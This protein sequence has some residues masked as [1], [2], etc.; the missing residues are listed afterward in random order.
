MRR[1]AVKPHRPR[2]C[3]RPP[4]EP[5]VAPARR[6]RRGRPRSG[7]GGYGLRNRSRHRLQH[8]NR[9]APSRAAACPTSSPACRRRR[10]RITSITMTQAQ[11]L[12]Q[13]LIDKILRRQ[14]ERSGRREFE[15]DVDAQFSQQRRGRRCRSDE[16]RRVGLEQAAWMRLEGDHRDRRRRFRRSR[17]TLDYRA[18]AAMDAV[19]LPNAPRRRVRRHRFGQ[20][21]D[22][23]V[24]Q[25]APRRVRMCARRRGLY[26]GGETGNR[27]PGGASWA[28][29]R[30]CRDPQHITTRHHRAGAAVCYLFSKAVKSMAAGISPG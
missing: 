17:G 29:A 16:R 2:G 25:R 11:T 14:Q 9:V 21:L 30:Y 8:V 18:V 15:E 4:P 23:D 10:R 27:V 24:A 6:R 3:P 20:G 7:I 1:L 22:Y 26:A 19:K 5:T 28:A 13:D 12:V